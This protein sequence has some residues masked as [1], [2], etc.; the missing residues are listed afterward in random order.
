MTTEPPSLAAL[1]WSRHFQMQVDPADSGL[2]PM[3]AMA[4]HRSEIEAAGADFSGR[5]P[6]LRPQATRARSPSATG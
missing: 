3:R 4:V 1:G 5:I 6:T 2:A